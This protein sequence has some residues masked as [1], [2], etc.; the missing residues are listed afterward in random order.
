MPAIQDVGSIE[1]KEGRLLTFPNMYMHKVL[2]FR[3]ADAT[4]PGHRKILAL[5]LVDPGAKVLSTAQVPPQRR[6]WWEQEAKWQQVMGRL[7][8]ELQMMV[9][10]QRDGAPFSEAQAKEI[11]EKLM[12]ERKMFAKEVD[13]AWKDSEGFSLCEH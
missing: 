2:P 12:D 3:L 9:N 8:V 1:C 11:R 13:A 6:D 7:P 5:F 10:E 4:K